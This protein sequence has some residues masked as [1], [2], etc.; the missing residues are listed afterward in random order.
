MADQGAQDVAS[1]GNK[2]AAEPIPQPETLHA[3]LP[4]DGV[5]RILSPDGGGAKGVYTL[6]V[7][8]E[9][10]AKRRALATAAEFE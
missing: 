5:H 6:G 4:K 1:D 3:E 2:E 7:L 9:I 10:D 8:K